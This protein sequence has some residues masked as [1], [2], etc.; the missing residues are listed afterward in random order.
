[1]IALSTDI[2]LDMM[3]ESCD[4]LFMT[5][6]ILKEALDEGKVSSLSVF[7]HMIFDECHTVMEGHSSNM[8]MNHY[9]QL[10]LDGTT[11][12][13]ELPQVGNVFLC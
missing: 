4:M 12:S 7:S 2:P 9:M 3:I 11:P 5:P 10:K 13:S 6:Q 8:L 1:M